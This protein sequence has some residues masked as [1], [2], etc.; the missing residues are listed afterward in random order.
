M[1]LLSQPFPP[2]VV[3]IA[4][5]S[6]SCCFYHSHFHIMLL[7]SQPFSHHVVVI[8]AIFTSCCCY[9]SPF[10][11]ML[12]L[13]QPF[14]HHVV[15]YLVASSFFFPDLVSI[16]NPAQS[17]QMMTLL[18]GVH[19]NASPAKQINQNSFSVDADSDT[20]LP[21]WQVSSHGDSDLVHVVDKPFAQ[22]RDSNRLS[23]DEATFVLVCK[24]P[25]HPL[26]PQPNPTL[27]KP[28]PTLT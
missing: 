20:G 8:T 9:C 19:T 10:H 27:T 1:L 26:S 3:V 16:I 18:S 15:Q 23:F 28:N 11:I 24:L 7:L 5:I 12:L 2:L 21:T 4:A 17:Q 22:K 14:S 13:S 6:T 25:Y